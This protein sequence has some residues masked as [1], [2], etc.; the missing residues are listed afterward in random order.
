[1]HNREVLKSPDNKKIKELQQ[2]SKKKTRK[3]RGVFVIEGIRF[4][5]SALEKNVALKD[6]YYSSA[7]LENSRG[8]QLVELIMSK[9]IRYHDVAPKLFNSISDTVNSQGILAIAPMPDAEEMIGEESGQVPKLSLILDRIQ[10]PGNLGTIIRTADAAGIKD[11]VLVKGTTDP[12]STKVLR[13]TMGSIFDVR[14]HF[15]ETD[16]VIDYMKENSIRIVATALEATDYHYELSVSD[17]LSLVI[18]N[19]GNG[20]SKAFMEAAD[21]LIKI[22][23]YGGAESLNA[24]VAAGIVLYDCA[25]RQ[26]N[27]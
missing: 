5:E 20:V 6:V 3:E 15:M 7:L 18:G 27:L 22:P 4:V 12:F 24:S 13:S 9:G 17:P 11:L 25:I 1:M 23:I 10:D 14:L 8:Q 2:L 19:E 16:E 21:E 26:R